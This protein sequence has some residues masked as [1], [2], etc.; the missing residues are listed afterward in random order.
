M[1]QCPELVSPPSEVK[2][3]HPVGAQRHCPPHSSEEKGEKKKER[4]KQTKKE[5]KKERERE[6]KRK[7]ERKKEMKVIKI[8]NKRIIK[9]LKVIKKN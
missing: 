7:K 9:N 2:T 6:I 3:W 1:D 8:K 5:R 4:N